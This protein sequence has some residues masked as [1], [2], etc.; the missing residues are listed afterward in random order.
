M[1]TVQSLC[2][3]VRKAYNIGLTLWT[4][5]LSSQLNNNVDHAQ[6]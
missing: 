6:Q 4:K 2:L 1:A 5:L 3:G